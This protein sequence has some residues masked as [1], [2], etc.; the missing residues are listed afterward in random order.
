M[1]SFFY[2]QACPDP[3]DCMSITEFTGDGTFPR[4]LDLGV[5]LSDALLI[6]HSRVN[7]GVPVSNTYKMF[8]SA[9]VDTF[10]HYGVGG[11][12]SWTAQTALETSGNAIV[13]Q[14]SGA[15]AADINTASR[16]GVILAFSKKRRFMDVA[17]YT[18]NNS[19]PPIG[20]TVGHALGKIPG[21]M[22]LANITSPQ[23]FL[24]CF[25][26]DGIVNRNVGSDPQ[27]S[28]PTWWDLE[29]GNGVWNSDA[30]FSN[31][32]LSAPNSN[33]FSVADTF[34][35]PTTNASGA[36]YVNFLFANDAG[37]VC[38]QGV[39]TGNGSA[40]G[41]II[42]LGWVPRMFWVIKNNIEASVSG[43][44][45]ILYDPTAAWTGNDSRFNPSATTVAPAPADWVAAD[46]TTG[47]Q[48]VTSSTDVN[49]NDIRYC[50]IA[51]K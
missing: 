17:R 21:F 39:Y 23:I 31:K 44:P 11:G 5:D 40:T 16:Q 34:N 12:S 9:E 18:G 22:M 20:A 2:G 26:K 47:V 42:T 50:Y 35:S 14:N 46:G 30:I 10:P 45:T 6:Y 32:W 38:Q 43:I 7:N 19:G 27:P 3:L 28:P 37:C 51:I 29:S 41:P 48:I 1:K 36:D 25:H 33:S 15:P 49:E 4:T 13:F 8:K 24:C